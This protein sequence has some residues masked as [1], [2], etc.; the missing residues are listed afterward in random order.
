MGGGALLA[1]I[2]FFVSCTALVRAKPKSP[3]FLLL[4]AALFL[5]A[6]ATAAGVYYGAGVLKDQTVAEA[7]NFAGQ[8]K[9]GNID[10]LLNNLQTGV[11]FP[12]REDIISILNMVKDK[13]AQQ[14][15][16]PQ[17][18]ADQQQGDQSGGSDQEGDG[19]QDDESQGDGEPAGGGE[20]Q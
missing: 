7:E 13:A 1:F 5:P 14:N 8:L 6:A 4:L 12:G 3:A 17:D 16:G 11:S 9:V 19:Q 10:Q 2:A 20:S 18:G 15:G